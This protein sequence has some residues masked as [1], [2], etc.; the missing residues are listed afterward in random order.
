MGA[1]LLVFATLWDTVFSE[2][3]LLYVVR[4]LS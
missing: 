2:L 1:E 3:R 4:M